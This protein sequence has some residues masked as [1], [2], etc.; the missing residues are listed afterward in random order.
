M[1]I[2][3]NSPSAVAPS[4]WERIVQRKEESPDLETRRSIFLGTDADTGVPVCVPRGTL[5]SSHFH[6]LGMTRAGKTAATLMPIVFQILRGYRDESGKPAPKSPVI[7]FDLKGDQAFFNATR[8]AALKAGRRFRFLS[9]RQGDDCR[10]QANSRAA[11][12]G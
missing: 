12:S 2:F 9:T 4:L 8:A 3:S 5:D 10:Y 1:S 6:V 7:I 11:S